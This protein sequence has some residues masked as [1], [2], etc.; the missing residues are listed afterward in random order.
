MSSP[1]QACGRIVGRRKFAQGL[2]FLDLCLIDGRRYQVC[3]KLE[4][5]AGGAEAMAEVGAFCL[6]DVISIVGVE[7]GRSTNRFGNPVINLERADLIER[8][9]SFH[10][11][12]ENR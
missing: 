10:L 6:G 11:P 3:A 2:L 4:V 8:W 12:S 1:L 9:Q 7:W 5:I